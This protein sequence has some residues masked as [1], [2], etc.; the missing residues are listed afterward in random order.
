MQIATFHDRHGLLL[1]NRWR[2]CT[3]AGMTTTVRIL[4][5]WAEAKRNCLSVISRMVANVFARVT[6]ASG[7]IS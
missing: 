3:V 4:M 7:P 2:S 1:P 6:S 5:A